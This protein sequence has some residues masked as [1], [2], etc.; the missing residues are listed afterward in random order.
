MRLNRLHLK[1]FKGVKDLT[2]EPGGADL[3]VRGENA[4]GKTTIMDAFMWLLF[5]KDSANRKDFEIK[6]LDESGQPIHGLDH[7]VEATLDIPGGSPDRADYIR[8]FKKTYREKWTQKRGAPKAIFS[9][10]T[11]DHFVDGVPVKQKEYE[12]A[13]SDLVPEE[14][15]RLLTDPRYFNTALHWT[16]R[17]EILLEACGDVPDSE[18]IASSEK[19]ARLPDILGDRTIEDH[20]KV[21]AARIKEIQ[22]ELDRIPIRIDEVYRGL[23]DISGI[24]KEEQESAIA[25]REEGIREKER[26]VNSIKSGGRGAELKTRIA[27]IMGRLQEKQNEARAGQGE[28]LGPL[29][30]EKSRISQEHV[31]A[32]NE[33]TRLERTLEQ[34]KEFIKQEEKRLEDLRQ[35]W[36]EADAQEYTEPEIEETC[37]TCGQEIPADQ[38]E[39]AREKARASFN[40]KKAATLERIQSE[41]KATK[42]KSER[43]M[44]EVA[45]LEEQYEATKAT[46]A[47]KLKEAEKISEKIT[48]AQNQGQADEGEDAESQQLVA[49]KREIEKE[50]ERLANEQQAHAQDLQDEIDREK[51]QVQ[52]EKATLQKLDQHA[53][54]QARIEELKKQERE[55][56]AEY[57]ALEKETYLTEEFIR[58]K[59]DLLEGK[60]NSYF[61]HATFKLFNVYISGGIEPTCETLYKGVP[62]STALNN[63]ARINVGLDII[64]TL[65]KHYNF[66]APIFIDNAEAITKLLPVNSQVIALEVSHDKNLT[67]EVI[68]EKAATS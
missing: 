68:E 64:N 57:E 11:I 28:A 21:I 54:G 23:P 35:E 67:V 62:Y 19:L 32:E 26:Q 36:I 4:T 2:L 33:K 15:F 6:T 14:T 9:G 59:V 51:E 39:E 41:G 40:N 24:N 29:F 17:R 13:I 42:E 12:A 56:S 45:E 66:K 49:E 43:L 10:H 8:T 27:E 46:A 1:N 53:A 3:V 25:A 34:Q 58:A 50:L 48:E 30:T 5:G 61:Q 44:K 55:L 22:K 18:V 38:V 16:K 20:R 65:S 60:I 63:G 7:E 47:A 31:E 52:Q 37:P